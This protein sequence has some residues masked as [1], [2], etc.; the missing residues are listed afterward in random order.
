[1]FNRPR[2]FS[3]AADFCIDNRQSTLFFVFVLIV[4]MQMLFQTSTGK[5]RHQEEPDS[6]R[7]YYNGHK[8]FYVR[9]QQVDDRRLDG[10]ERAYKEHG[11][12]EHDVCEL[13]I[14]LVFDGQLACL[15]EHGVN[16]GLC[17]KQGKP[18]RDKQRGD[19]HTESPPDCHLHTL[20]SHLPVFER[21]RPILRI[22]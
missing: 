19:K 16:L 6:E 7:D 18:S 8:D 14:T 15:S 3:A 2:L 10:D 12:R 20:S 13:P 22:I 5:P 21:Y 1:M 11:E 17:D 4:F 9:F